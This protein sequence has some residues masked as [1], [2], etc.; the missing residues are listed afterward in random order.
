MTVVAAVATFGRAMPQ[1]VADVEASVETAD[2]GG[3]E[4]AI[5]RGGAVTVDEAAFA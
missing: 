4:G 3:V 2:G 1:M 5:G